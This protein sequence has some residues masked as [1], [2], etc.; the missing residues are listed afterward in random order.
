VK[1]A[2]PVRYTARAR[3]SQ[4]GARYEKLGGAARLE[5]NWDDAAS[6]ILV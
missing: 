5:I 2:I 6:E 3:L 1:E 4:I